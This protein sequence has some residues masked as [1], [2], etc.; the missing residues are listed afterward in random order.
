MNRA[1]WRLGVAAEDM[2]LP[3]IATREINRPDR[4]AATA[5]TV[6]GS[7]RYLIDARTPS[8]V[9]VDGMGAAAEGDVVECDESNNSA[10]TAAA[11]C[12]SAG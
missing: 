2:R 5:P 6:T 4:V 11:A 1:S 8:R 12:P 10:S 7:W 9:E 3:T